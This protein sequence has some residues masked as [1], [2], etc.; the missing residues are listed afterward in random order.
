[1]SIWSDDTINRFAAE[2]ELEIATQVSCITKRI[3]IT[4][5]SGRSVYLIPDD[6]LILRRVTYQGKKLEPRHFN[7]LLEY[8]ILNPAGTNGAFYHLAF[9][10]LGFDSGDSDSTPQNTPY[11]YYYNGYGENLIKLFPTPS[12]NLI[13]PASPNLFG[14]GIINC[15]IVEYYAFPTLT[16]NTYRVPSYV[17]RRMIKSYVLSKCYSQEGPGQDLI[18]SVRHMKRFNM[19]ILEFKLINDGVFVSR[20]RTRTPNSG[21]YPAKIGRPVLPSNFGT[22]VE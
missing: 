8:P 3:A 1:M 21:S 10:T 7:S 6:C 19:Q 9:Y 15:C 22:I 16:G 12:A 5:F 2:A 18:A 4:V 14:S 20:V 17:A 11:E 13:P